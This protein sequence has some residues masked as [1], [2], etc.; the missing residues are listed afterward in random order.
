[1]CT[2]VF[3][4]LLDFVKRASWFHKSAFCIR[5]PCLSSPYIL[6]FF[7]GSAD[8]GDPCWTSGLVYQ[9]NSE[10]TDPSRHQWPAESRS[11]KDT[12]ACVCVCLAPGNSSLS[13]PSPAVPR[14][15]TCLH[16]LP[17]APIQRR[18][19]LAVA[20]K[21]SRPNKG[22]QATIWPCP[23]RSRH[24]HRHRPRRPAVYTLSLSHPPLDSCG[25]CDVCDLVTWP[26]L[27]LFVSREGK[28]FQ[29]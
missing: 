20:K 21:V 14:A 8:P 10:N 7:F 3:I 11:F 18:R 25:P 29:A 19:S 16:C 2:L 1:M 4:V 12:G 13:S 17:F 27:V 23:A 15:D 5:R 26:A 22:R 28:K 9:Q 24:R 6:V